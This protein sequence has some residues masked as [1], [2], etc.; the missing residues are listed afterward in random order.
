MTTTS[1]YSK[2]TEFEV[3][4]KFMEESIQYLQSVAG[5]RG[6]ALDGYENWLAIG[7]ING[8]MN[9]S[10]VL[11]STGVVYIFH[12]NDNK[13]WTLYSTIQSSNAVPMSGEMFGC[14]LSFSR[15]NNLKLAIGSCGDK[16][17]MPSKVG[18]YDYHSDTSIWALDSVLPNR[19]ELGVRNGY[20]KYSI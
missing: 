19:H 16:P 12:K 4:P 3:K 11:V 6:G 20:G 2:N 7:N 14:S 9:S 1:R 13:K 5:G 17:G 15:S 10:N 18:V 8:Q